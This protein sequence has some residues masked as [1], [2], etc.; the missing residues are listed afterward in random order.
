[1]GI[2]QRLCDYADAEGGIGERVYKHIA[3]TPSDIRELNPEVPAGLSGGVPS[4]QV[5]VSVVLPG[6]Q[7]VVRLLCG[8]PPCRSSG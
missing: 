7:T 6:G 2:G 3:A 5:R 8:Q 1:M 4:F